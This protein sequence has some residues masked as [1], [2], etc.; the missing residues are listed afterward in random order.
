MPDQLSLSLWLRGFDSETMLP[1][2]GE[3]LGAFPFSALRPGISG[4]RIYA[5]EFTEPALFERAFA[6]GEAGLD[7]AIELA[8]E[9]RAADCAYLLEGFWDLWR[10]D[11]TGNWQLS[12][13][14]VVLSCFGPEFESEI[15]DHLRLE[16]GPEDRF[17]P[18]PG[19][20][21]GARKAHSN[22]QSIVRL[23]RD[24]EARVPIERQSLWSESGEDFA[25]RLLE[26]ADEAD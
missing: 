8:E 15:G 17:L 25:E 10:L 16:L 13:S 23:A 19:A 12:P 11:P 22:L 9:F 26:L 24:I 1:G 6:A 21:Q 18:P 2:F 4:L 7:A 5:I 14:P 3:A 20:P